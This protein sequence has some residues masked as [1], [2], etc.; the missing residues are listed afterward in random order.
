MNYDKILAERKDKKIYKLGDTAVKVFD[1]TYSKSDI[2]NEALNQARVEETGLTI[3]KILEVS[4]IDGNWAITTS[5][6]EG[7]TLSEIMKEDRANLSKYIEKLV[8]IQLE[9]HTKTAVSLNKL[10]DKMGDKIDAAGI[11][12]TS[13]YELHARLESMPRHTK[14]CHGDFNPSNIIIGVEG[15]AYILDWSHAAQGNASSDAAMTYLY[16]CLENDIEAA[17][18]YLNMFCKKN[19]TAKQYVHQWL[20]I[21]AAAQ[22]S[23]GKAEER[24][25]LLRWIDVFDY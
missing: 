8:D 2:L 5:Y 17:E 25:F 4:K 3:P 10:R 13:R 6:I 11:D 18:L 15:T 14:V 9:M 24:E 7:R 22:L 20:P 23:R 1:I 12:A 19:D 16:F 21:V